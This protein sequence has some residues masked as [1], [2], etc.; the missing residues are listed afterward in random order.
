MTM[1]QIFISISFLI[2]GL[3]SGFTMGIIFSLDKL[4]RERRR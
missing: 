4:D 2:L 3:I 1:L